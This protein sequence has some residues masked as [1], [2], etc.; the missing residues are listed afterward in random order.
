MRL[1]P[2]VR[3][4]PRCVAEEPQPPLCADRGVELADAAG[5]DVAGVGERWPA[6]LFVLA[7]RSTAPGRNWS[8]RF[9]CGFPKRR[10]ARPHTPCAETAPSGNGTRRVL[11]TQPQWNVF[12]RADVV[13]DIVAHFGRCRAALA[14]R[15]QRRPR[16][17]AKRPRHRP[18]IRRPTRSF[19]LG[20]SLAT[21]SPYFL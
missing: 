8:C 1:W 6:L 17:S 20:K 12:D 11:T 5:R 16:R 9:R 21:R 3:V 2:S 18:S 14:V 7:P 10:Q 15:Q 19:R 13:G 4:S